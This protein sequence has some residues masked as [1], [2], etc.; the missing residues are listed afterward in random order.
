MRGRV[1]DGVIQS[2]GRCCHALCTR[3]FFDCLIKDPTPGRRR[4]GLLG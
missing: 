3:I 1:A 4:E 2:N